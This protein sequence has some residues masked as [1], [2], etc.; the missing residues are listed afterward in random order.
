MNSINGKEATM[1]QNTE[2]AMAT[3]NQGQTSSSQSPKPEKPKKK[4]RAVPV[5][6]KKMAEASKIFNYQLTKSNAVKLECVQ[7]IFE[8]APDVEKLWGQFMAEVNRLLDSRRYYAECAALKVSPENLAEHIVLLGKPTVN[9]VLDKGII[10]TIGTDYLL[11]VERFTRP[12]DVDIYL[13]TYYD[14]ARKRP[15]ASKTA[16]DKAEEPSATGEVA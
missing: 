10:A 3:Q 8:S 7:K 1:P 9:K 11:Y 2:V 15:E 5:L 16:E 12:E 14:G 13:P 4:K 6:P